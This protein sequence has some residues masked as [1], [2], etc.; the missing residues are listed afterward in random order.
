MKA[1]H[2]TTLP[3]KS[4][5]LRSACA[6]A[7][8]ALSAGTAFAEFD[9]LQPISPDPATSA[10]PRF[11]LTTGIALGTSYYFIANDI[12]ANSVVPG[13]TT[14]YK[15]TSGGIEQ[16]LDQNGA[17][18][19]RAT[20]LV[21]FGNGLAVSSTDGV[22]FL[23]DDSALNTQFINGSQAETRQLLAQGSPALLYLINA[24]STLAT[25]DGTN[26][27][28]VPNALASNPD[29]AADDSLMAPIGEQTVVF[30]RQET[31]AA[32]INSFSP[33]VA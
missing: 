23:S 17:N 24:D 11:N 21:P 30:V 10:A 33:H 9:R 32:G 2:S 6:V 26:L 5:I 25:S 13:N 31:D 27:N 12:G 7:I 16:V 1:N 3:R 15:A 14:F 8:G 19:R 4:A 22:D 20:A 18:L 29:C 28:A